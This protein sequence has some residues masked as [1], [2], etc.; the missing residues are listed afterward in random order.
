[1]LACPTCKNDDLIPARLSKADS[2]LDIFRCTL[3]NT[4]FSRWE[5]DDVDESR[6]DA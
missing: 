4:N 3:C 6:E 2:R 5:A 1:M